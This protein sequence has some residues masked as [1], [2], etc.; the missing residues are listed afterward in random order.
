MAIGTIDI[1]YSVLLENGDIVQMTSGQLARYRF[2]T[3]YIMPVL[4]VLFSPARW[5]IKIA[6]K[7]KYGRKISRQDISPNRN[8]NEP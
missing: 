3:K 6:K 8:H 4:W 1:L 2:F 5:A 7:L